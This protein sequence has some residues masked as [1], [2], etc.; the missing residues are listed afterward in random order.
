[1]VLEPEDWSLNKVKYNHY[2]LIVQRGSE[3]SWNANGPY[4]AQ[5]LST[6]YIFKRLMIV[7]IR[8]VGY[9]LPELSYGLRAA[10]FLFILLL[11]KPIY[12]F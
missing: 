5:A 2:L 12:M 9:P 3:L 7:V 1:M 10:S 11:N 8:K 4:S 6:D